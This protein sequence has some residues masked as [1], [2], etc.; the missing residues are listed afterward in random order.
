MC[1]I[2]PPLTSRRTLQ[3]VAQGLKDCSVPSDNQPV[4]RAGLRSLCDAQSIT[5]GLFLSLESG[6]Q[7]GLPHKLIPS[8]TP[9]PTL[10]QA[11]A[12][13]PMSTLAP[14]QLHLNSNSSSSPSPSLTLILAL[15]NCS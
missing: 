7:D 6:R 14:N 4:C 5:T 13:V 3:M 1:L 2:K 9:T 11:S 12:P 15:N 8:P 10:V